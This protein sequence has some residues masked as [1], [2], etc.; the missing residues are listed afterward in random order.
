LYHLAV[1]ISGEEVWL[2]AEC[3]GLSEGLLRSSQL[4]STLQLVQV[5]AAL[6][7]RLQEWIASFETLLLLDL[8]R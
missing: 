8:D 2:S 7:I 6:E 3:V 4:E 5:K 1:F